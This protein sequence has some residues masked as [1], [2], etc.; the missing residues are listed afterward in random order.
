MRKFNPGRLQSDEELKEQFVVRK[1]ELGILL[2]VL[3]GNIGSNSC[4]HALIVAPRGRGKTMLLARAAAEVR[5]N[6]EFSKHFLPVRFGEENRDIYNLAEFWFETLFHLAGACA[7]RHPR[8]SRE[9]REK[10]AGLTGRWGEE[11]LEEHARAAVLDAADQLNRRL[12]L[13][14][15]NLQTLRKFVD[16][17]FG[18]K[19][20]GVLQTEPQ[21]VLLA[22]ATSRFAGLD[23]AT[24]PYFEMF[25]VVNLNPMTTDECRC[26]WEVISRDDVSGRKMRP[27]EILTGG[28]PRLLVMVANFSR[29][30]SL[31]SLMEELVALIDEHTEYFRSNLEA[32]SKTEGR[33]FIAIL[34]LWQPSSTSEIAAR[35]RMDVRNVSTMIGRLIERGALFV[36][37]PKKRRKYAAAEPLFS[38]YF[39]LRRSSDE[40]A[41]VENLIRFMTVFYSEEE[42]TEMF[43][44]VIAEARKSST[45]RE[46]LDRAAAG[47]PELARRPDNLTV[48][49]ISSTRTI[50]GD[51]DQI[52][53]AEH[54]DHTERID[55]DLNSALAQQMKEISLAAKEK[56][57]E[58]VIDLADRFVAAHLKDTS[59]EWQAP[60]AWTLNAKG[61]ASTHSGDLK[62]ALLAFRE[63]VQRFGESANSTVQGLVAEALICR[64]HADRLLGDVDSALLAFDEV[65]QRLGSSRDNWRRTW[66]ARALICKGIAL[67]ESG[68]NNS[69]LPVFE[70]I[71]KRFGRSKHVDI[72]CSVALALHHRAD[73]FWLLG[74][75]ETAVSTNEEIVL[76]F[77]A[78]SDM[79]LQ[80]YV[81]IALVTIGYIREA[82][83]DLHDARSACQ[84][85][86]DLYG[87]IWELH[88][89][90]A[91]ALLLKGRLLQA[92]GDS[93]L[94]E[95]TYDEII[96][97]YGSGQNE[98][99]DIWI[100]RALERMAG[101]QN[102]LGKPDQVV[103]ACDEILERFGATEH[104]EIAPY[105]AR[106]MGSK[107]DALRELGN[108]DSAIS[109]FDESL[110]RFGGSED[111]VLNLVSA[112]SLIS[113]G[114]T[115]VVLEQL[116]AAVDVF[117]E[118]VARFGNSKDSSLLWWVALAMRWKALVLMRSGNDQAALV[119]YDEI[120]N[121]FQA[122]DDS[123]LRE[124]ILEARIDKAKLLI[125][126]GYPENAVRELRELEQSIEE[127]DEERAVQIRWHAHYQSTRALLA[128][129][130]LEAALEMFRSL[131]KEFVPSD[132]RMLRKM[133]ELTPQLIA[134][135]ASAFDLVEILS[136]DRDKSLTMAP[137]LVALRQ[138]AGEAV[139]APE[140][141]MKVASDIR[142]QIDGE[143]SGTFEST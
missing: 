142:L 113:K 101:L 41:I 44:L 140:E 20:R 38:I 92:A 115:L 31:R 64:G 87:S 81:A 2:D 95:S 83:G 84:K 23:D 137:L 33:V 40:A 24:Q 102:A 107:G 3:R 77:E 56:E 127:L 132:E 82:M 13:M 75:L 47:L 21:I 37:G 9:L 86:V 42:K 89:W 50:E 119:A 60:I 100:A 138:H 7:T 11:A 55:P 133:I 34:D 16:E 1:Y 125:L 14:L 97:R 18:W 68:D 111:P 53:S 109:V 103:L 8:L 63:V 12:V 94:E 35:A 96:E 62:A 120:V 91:E 117:E 79:D 76:R 108:F 45:I 122:A 73:I 46:G 70:E 28:N 43:S 121:R 22:S 6:P 27:L 131:H 141:V 78:S 30:K 71:S 32:L 19:L 51:P 128:R 85:I 57:F 112:V 36:Q 4:Q 72:Q 106:A 61:H 59:E 80:Q 54:R 90:A 15:E 110:E 74:N 126:T 67:R 129:N 93:E 136:G 124:S 58:K 135:G 52:T 5:T 26:L 65:V 130:D 88:R 104:R 114:S 98:E 48:P 66:V 10:Y 116:D 139:R 134:G 69:A 123:D 39:K 143:G 99:L 29:H 17:D 25:R 118:S 105:V 49:K